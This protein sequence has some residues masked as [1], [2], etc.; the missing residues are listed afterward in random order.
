MEK[1]EILY[2]IESMDTV[3]VSSLLTL[4]AF[5]MSS[6]SADSVVSIASVAPAHEKKKSCCPFG[7]CKK[8]MTTAE[9]MMTCRCG[10][11]FCTTHRLPEQH[12]CGFNYRAAA[13]QHLSTQL[14]KCAGERLMD[15]V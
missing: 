6:I 4:P 11:A 13:T 1:I 2:K 9:S 7:D 14:V 3:H 5:T 10:V 15:K 8:R 12:M